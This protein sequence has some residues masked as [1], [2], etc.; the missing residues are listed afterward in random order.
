MRR[1]PRDPSSE[2][3]KHLS[4]GNN[5][6][7]RSSILNPAHVLDNA[8]S[9]AS[10]DLMRSLLQTM[11]NALLSAEAAAVCGAEYGMPSSDRRVSSDGALV[12][13]EQYRGDVQGR[14]SVC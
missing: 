4:K 2:T 5:H 14:C 11:I 13:R 3:S 7:D 9:D 10:P 12:V 6:D 1:S 8:L